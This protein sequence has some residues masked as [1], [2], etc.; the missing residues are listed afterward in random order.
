[1][2]ICPVLCYRTNFIN[3]K[4]LLHFGVWWWVKK[5][6][7]KATVFLELH[8]HIHTHVLLLTTIFVEQCKKIK[9]KETK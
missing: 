5:R 3:V 4:I 9:M 1:M 7:K 6:E 2:E 8:T